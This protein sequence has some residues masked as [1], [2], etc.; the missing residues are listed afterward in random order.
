MSFITLEFIVLVHKPLSILIACISATIVTLTFIVATLTT[1]D[2]YLIGLIGFATSIAV[3]LLCFYLLCFHLLIA[4]ERKAV[5]DTRNV[6]ASDKRKYGE[7]GNR[8]DAKASEL[9]INSAE[10]SYFLEQ[11][12]SAIEQSSDD[13]NTLAAAAEQMS[14]N[15]NQMNE[16]ALL[17]SNQANNAMSGSETCSN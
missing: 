3:Y 4:K 13:V 2:N 15:T 17:A 5:N 9:A 16:N 7:M 11:L 14:L 12:S 10:V 1:T 6:I 8:I